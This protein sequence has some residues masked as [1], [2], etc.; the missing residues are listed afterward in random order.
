MRFYLDIG[1]TSYVSIFGN[2][3]EMII[4][5]FEFNWLIF[6]KYWDCFYFLI[7]KVYDAR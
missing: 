5:I 6:I 2:Y 7:Y 3:F 1:D 4:S